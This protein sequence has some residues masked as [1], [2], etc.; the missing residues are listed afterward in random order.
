LDRDREPPST[1]LGHYRFIAAAPGLNSGALRRAAE[2]RQMG[3][4]R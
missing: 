3:R 4:G 1:G 2:I